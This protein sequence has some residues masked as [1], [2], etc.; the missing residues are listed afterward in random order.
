MIQGIKINGFPAVQVTLNLNFTEQEMA[1]YIDRY[2]D[3]GWIVGCE[4]RCTARPQAPIKYC[5]AI[6]R[7]Q[8]QRRDVIASYRIKEVA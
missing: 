5:Y 6:E 2:E 4:I 8:M 1:D 3:R 7:T